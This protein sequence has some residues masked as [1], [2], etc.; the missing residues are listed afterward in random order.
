VPA[1]LGEAAVALWA[2]AADAL[3]ADADHTEIARWVSERAAE[4]V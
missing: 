1:R 4:T 2:D 3:P